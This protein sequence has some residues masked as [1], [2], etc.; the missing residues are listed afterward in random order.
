MTAIERLLVNAREGW[1]A[2][3]LDLSVTYVV[4]ATRPNA[5]L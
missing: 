5:P 3:D 2:P 1:V 4:R